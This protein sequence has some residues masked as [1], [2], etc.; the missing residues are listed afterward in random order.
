MYIF[1]VLQKFKVWKLQKRFGVQ[2]ANLQNFTIAAS[3][4]IRKFLSPKI[5]DLW[6]LFPQ[7]YILVF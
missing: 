3:P 7:L 2:I 6:N 5:C 1:A 4:Q